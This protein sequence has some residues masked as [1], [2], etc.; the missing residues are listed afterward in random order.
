MP[1]G[2]VGE[3]VCH[4]GRWITRSVATNPLFYSSEIKVCF[5]L[6]S[7]LWGCRGGSVS[8]RTLDYARNHGHVPHRC[9]H[10]PSQR[11]HSNIQVSIIAC[12]HSDKLTLTLLM[13]RLLSSKAQ[14]CKDFWK[15][16]KP[17]Q[18]GIHWKALAEYSQMSTHLPGFQSFFRDFCIILYWTN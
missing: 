3:E 14:G 15:T 5:S 4:P 8:S 13:L 7:A 2:G 12:C 17:C 10:P 16:S 11:T 18:V 6:A 9:Q 1:C